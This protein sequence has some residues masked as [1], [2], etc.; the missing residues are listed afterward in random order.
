MAT[1]P[2]ISTRNRRCS[3]WAIGLLLLCAG[4]VGWG[5]PQNTPT[6]EPWTK[7]WRSKSKTTSGFGVNSEAKEIERDL[8]VY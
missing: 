8:G 3:C 7:P 5:P 6:E 1:R 2:L 4:C